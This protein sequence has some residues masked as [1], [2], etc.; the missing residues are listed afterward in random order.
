MGSHPVIDLD[1]LLDGF[2]ENLKGKL[3]E[4][5]KI[6]FWNLLNDPDVQRAHEKLVFSME[7]VLRN[8]LALQ[9]RGLEVK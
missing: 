8:S 9:K 7:E 1:D 5:Q 2:R 6:A 3:S 4:N